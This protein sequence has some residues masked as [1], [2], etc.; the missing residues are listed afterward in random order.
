MIDVGGEKRH[1]HNSIE[2]AIHNTD[3]GIRNF[4]RWFGDDTLGRPTSCVSW[5]KCTCVFRWRD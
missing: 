3:E 2:H 5:Y 4:H 1:R